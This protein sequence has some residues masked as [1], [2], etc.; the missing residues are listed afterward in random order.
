MDGTI[1]IDGT[2][3][4]VMACWMNGEIVTV[5]MVSGGVEHC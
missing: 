5:T 3:G 1:R 4:V 2:I